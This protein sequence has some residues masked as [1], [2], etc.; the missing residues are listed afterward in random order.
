MK[1]PAVLILTALAALGVFALCSGKEWRKSSTT[2]R[3][4]PIPPALND[5]EPASTFSIVARDPAN[6]DLGVAVA[7]RYFG[8]GNVVPWARAG[9][10]AV[11]T[12]SYANA[13]YGPR[14]LD[15]LA[16]GQSPEEA[17]GVLTASDER[18]EWRQAAIVDS[19]G[20]VA[21]HTGKECLAWA[22]H[23]SGAGYSVQGNI[24]VARSTIDA[25]AVAFESTEGPLPHRLVAALEAAERS[26]GDA[27]GRQSAAILVVRVPE[28]DDGRSDRWVD[29]RV[30]DHRRPVA[31]LRRLVDLRL[32][33]DPI[34]R[35]EEELRRSGDL[36]AAAAALDRALANYPDWD[37]IA[38][39]KARLL[40]RGGRADAAA[41]VLDA[42]VAKDPDDGMTAWLAAR[43]H[44]EAGDARRAIDRLRRLLERQPEFRDAWDR[45]WGDPKSALRRALPNGLDTKTESPPK[46]R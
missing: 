42:I 30:D 15:L 35:A 24:L 12:Q 33:R 7:S 13:S 26:G 14:G 16:G 9:V 45:E 28:R 10:G 44:A 37:D 23:R 3:G 27:R 6:G 22:G 36:D 41:A 5:A 38:W 46:E 40:A 20:R 29:L 2:P 11:A 32:G 43:V 8:A 39:T 18:R 4:N 17:L 19:S 34:R 21:V 25:M 1:T 31:E